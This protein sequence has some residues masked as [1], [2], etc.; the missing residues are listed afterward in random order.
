MSTASHR[1]LRSIDR[2]CLNGSIGAFAAMAVLLLGALAAGPAWADLPYFVSADATATV[3]TLDSQTDSTGQRQ[4]FPV[5]AGPVSADGS[6]FSPDDSAAATSTADMGELTAYASAN[7]TD[8]LL[9][10]GRGGAT[11]WLD[12]FTASS[13]TPGVTE[14]TFQ[15][16]LSLFD[17]ITASASTIGEAHVDFILSDS[18]HIDPVTLLS[19]DDASFNPP[20]NARTV[21]AMFTE[22]IGV[23][24]VLSGRLVVT[25]RAGDPFGEEGFVVVDATEGATFKLDPTTPDG[26]YTTASGVSYLSSP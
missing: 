21:T 9:V 14:V 15:A 5:I 25:A 26:A 4:I 16:T 13:S 22:P 20:L 6:P 7:V 1:L 19:L 8:G 23:P 2:P 3:G 12:T 18:T 11:D 17:T 24:F 10:L